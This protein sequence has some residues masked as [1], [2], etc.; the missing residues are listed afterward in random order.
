MKIPQLTA[1]LLLALAGGVAAQTTDAAKPNAE[2]EKALMKMEQDVSAALTKADADALSKAL[3]DD[4]YAVNPDGTTQSKA[5]FVADLKSGKFKLE[6]NKL[7]DMKVRAAGA[8][9]AVVTYRS[10]DKGSVA[11]QDISG[12]YRWVDVFAKRGGTWQIIVSQGTRL[13][14]GKGQ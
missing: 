8:D 9:M 7:D 4:F 10:A 11:G 12:Q 3:A 6:S 1:I 14:Q 5:E 2:T 13:E